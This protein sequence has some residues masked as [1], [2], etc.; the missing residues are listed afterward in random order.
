[1]FAL[2]ILLVW[3]LVAL[4]GGG[5]TVWFVL[6]VWKRRKSVWLTAKV[7]AAL[8]TASASFG[9]LGTLTGLVHAFGA[10]GGERV[11]PSQKARILAEGNS[12]AMN[13]TALVVVVLVPTLVVL[14]ILMRG[15][16]ERSQ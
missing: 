15:S 14:A 16:R 7:M 13:C 9:L 12:E 8:A 2:G 6:R 11:E 3:L 10:I 4:L 5:V 1:M